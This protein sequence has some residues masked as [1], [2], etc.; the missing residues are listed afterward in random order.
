MLNVSLKLSGNETEIQKQKLIL[1]ASLMEKAINSVKFKNAILN[2]ERTEWWSTG[3]L[4]WK[5]WHSRKVKG[6]S[7]CS[8]SNE[9]VLKHIMAGGEDLSP[10]KDQEA[11]IQVTVAVGSRGVIGWTNPHTPM[12]WISSWFINSSSVD[13]HEV[14]GNLAHEWC[15][16]LGFDHAFQPYSGREDTVPYSVG[17]LIEKISREDS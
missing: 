3:K 11:D 10:E 16:K 9:E 8:M 12:Q 1:A 5:K 6:F 2:Y 4:W 13:A 15:H 14:A 7:E 17:Y